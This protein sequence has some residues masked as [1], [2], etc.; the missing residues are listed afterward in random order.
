ME[1]VSA[2][3][4]VTRELMA[5]AGKI[6]DV[7]IFS[8]N[9]TGGTG[10]EGL[11]K[12]ILN[13]GMLMPLLEE[14]ASGKNVKDL[15]GTLSTITNQNKPE[16]TNIDVYQQP[17]KDSASSDNTEEIKLKTSGKQEKE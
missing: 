11:G 4:E 15:I 1:L 3:P 14:I 7:K 10:S 13:S 6:S 12:T 8:M 5:P 17:D 16:D 9:G 2:M